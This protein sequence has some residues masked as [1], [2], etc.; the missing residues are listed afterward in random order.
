MLSTIVQLVSSEFT[1][2]H[3]KSMAKQWLK[4]RNLELNPS[5]FIVK[6]SVVRHNEMQSELNTPCYSHHL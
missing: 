5:P 1:S 4:T 3:R 2:Q 6:S